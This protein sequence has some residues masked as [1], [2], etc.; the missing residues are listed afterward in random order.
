MRQLLPHYYVS[1]RPLG[2]K[3]SECGQVFGNRAEQDQEQQLASPSG[4]IQTEFDGHN[5]ENYRAKIKQHRQS[6]R[7]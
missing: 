4:A 3:C 7:V 5:C 2:W 1:T 6:L